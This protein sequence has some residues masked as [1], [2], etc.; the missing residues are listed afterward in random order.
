LAT[1]GQER[2][3][4]LLLGS[5]KSNIGHTQAAAGVAGVIK[6]V[7]AMRH[8][9]VPPSLHIDAP[10]SHVDWASGAVD[11]V[12]EETP[13]PDTGRPRRVGVS[14]FGLSGTNAHV[15]L[16][17]GPEPEPSAEAY[18]GVVPL[19]VSARSEQALDERLRQ[20]QGHP[21]S[22]DVGYSLAVGRSRFEHRAVALAT[23]DGLEQVAR[24]VTSGGS[25]A[26]VF[27]GQGAQRLAMGRGLYERFPVFA[28]A[29]D[30]V[31][32]ELDPALRGVMWGE[33]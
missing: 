12:R 32:A 7:M 23:A 18:A 20:L 22:A 17:A 19:V 9:V 11:L 2:E 29:L 5:V 8:G 30:A 33:D 6:S 28:E 25:L 21:L 13:W 24:G 1:Y 14:S 3:R 10:S 27:S 15:V 4:P 31:L 16:E 26:V